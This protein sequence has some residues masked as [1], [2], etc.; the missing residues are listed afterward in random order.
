MQKYPD[1]AGGGEVD[2]YLCQKCLP[3]WDTFDRKA[4]EAHTA[5]NLHNRP[6]EKLQVQP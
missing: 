6:G 2:I 3:V 1:A 5:A 4:A